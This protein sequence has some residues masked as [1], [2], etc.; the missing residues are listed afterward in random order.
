MRKD[1]DK[2][3]FLTKAPV[4]R[5]ITTLAVPTIISMLITSAYNMSDTYFVGRLN[6]QCT[7][8]VGVSFSIMSVI[9]AIGF[10]FGHGSG[11][12]MSRALG[13]RCISRAR[14]M[15]TTG[16]LFS[17]ALGCCVAIVGS[18][19]LERI[20]LWLGSTPTVLP[21]TMDYLGIVFWGAPM[22]TSSFTM[23]N[24]MRFQGNALYA[25]YGVLSGAL[26]NIILDPLLIFCFGMGIQGAAYA[27][28][29]SQSIGFL[30]L[31]WMTFRG[32]GV[33]IHLSLFSP[34]ALFLKEIF[35]G[36]TPSLSRQG[37]ASFS[38]IMLNVSAGQYGD[39]AIAAMSIVS[40]FCFFIFAIII[41][42]GQGFQPLCGFCYGAKLFHRV[43]EGFF[44]CVK[45]GTLFLVTVAV[46]GFIF[47]P[48]IVKEFRHDP[49]VINI[50]ARALR[51]QFIT[52]PLLP[53]IGIS[54]MYLQTIRKPLAA[55]FVA[56]ARSG[57]FFIPLIIILP[58]FLGLTGVEICQ[59]VSDVCT[60]VVA[61]PVTLHTLNAMEK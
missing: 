25:M 53:L 23:N 20:A 35:L 39:A 43:R 61:L 34:R 9:Q 42:F 10:F 50:G 14:R 6:T 46:V 24:Q 4:S 49:Y 30:I 33:G 38:T 47:A 26:L 51:W 58:Y 7:A 31:L 12:F 59:S 40:R 57:L 28:L 13:A 21:Y 41:G 54:N 44:F 16:F 18:F 32:G 27:T 36:G 17:F 3:I 56:A 29:I 19:F 2:Y 1:R 15:A 60:F 8:A 55:N 48:E 52:F 22:M 5:V 45:N 11:N 37:L